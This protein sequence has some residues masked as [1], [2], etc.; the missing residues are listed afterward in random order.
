MGQEK[1]QVQYQQN[2]KNVFSAGCGTK[3][4]LTKTL[5]IELRQPVAY[6]P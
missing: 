6:R 2:T 1:N 3:C 4:P 5:C